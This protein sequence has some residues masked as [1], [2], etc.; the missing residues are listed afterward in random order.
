MIKLV[1]RAERN[2]YLIILQKH[3]YS[4]DL[5]TAWKEL[6]PAYSIDFRAIVYGEFP[7]STRG[8]INSLR[9]I[10]ARLKRIHW[11]L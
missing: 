11:E 10:Q 2:G 8:F 9:D 3:Y 5:E 1:S 7:E 6:I 4:G